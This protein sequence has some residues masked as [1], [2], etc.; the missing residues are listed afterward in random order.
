MMD[1]QWAKRWE[2]LLS[3]HCAMA[4][5]GVFCGYS[6]EERDV[7]WQGRG[8][9]GRERKGYLNMEDVKSSE[10]LCRVTQSPDCVCAGLSSRVEGAY[11]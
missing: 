3:E 4:F 11:R 6:P 10:V 7:F 8:R 1:A 2:R 9:E 5:T